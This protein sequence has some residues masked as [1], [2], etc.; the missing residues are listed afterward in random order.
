V[1]VPEPVFQQP[2]EVLLG[3][4][5]S[6]CDAIGARVVVRSASGDVVTWATVARDGEHMEAPGTERLWEAIAVQVMDDR[7][8]QLTSGAAGLPAVV[9]AVPLDAPAGQSGAL[10][11]GF[12]VEALGGAT[13]LLWMASSFAHTMSLCLDDPGGFGRMIGAAVVDPLT[14]CHNALAMWEC[15]DRE[16]SRSSRQRTPLACTFVDLDNFKDVNEAGGHLNGDVVLAAVG[17]ALSACVRGYDTVARF[18]GDEF[19]VVMPNSTEKQARALV[20][21]MAHEISA[22]T[23]SLCEVPVTASFGTSQLRFDEPAAALLQRADQRMLESKRARRESAA[24]TQ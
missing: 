15:L 20:A 19:V 9:A 21:R 12:D 10:C 11:C 23:S 14:Q 7:C 6:R 3:R 2:L 22:A 1:S 4:F 24:V 17:A 18:G 16:I 8:V 5:A 13:R